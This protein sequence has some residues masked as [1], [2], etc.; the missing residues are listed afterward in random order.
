MP[1]RLCKNIEKGADEEGIYICCECVVT[2]GSI[3]KP[4]ARTLVDKLYLADRADDARFVEK[5]IFG[6]NNLSAETPVLKKRVIPLKIRR[7][8][9]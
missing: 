5:I 9:I 1:C 7:R 2:I 6:G 4:D 3:S 8:T